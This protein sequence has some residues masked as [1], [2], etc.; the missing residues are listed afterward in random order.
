MMLPRTQ[1]VSFAALVAIR[2][3]W[4]EQDQTFRGLRHNHPAGIRLQQSF[5]IGV[6][7]VAKE[8]KTKSA[9]ALEGAMAAAPTA[10]Q[11]AKQGDDVTLEVGRFRDLRVGE[12]R[13]DGRQDG[14]E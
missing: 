12:A 8:R 9:L 14:R 10:T 3:G 4:L 7:I 1:L 2:V 13:I 5:V 6:E 11:T